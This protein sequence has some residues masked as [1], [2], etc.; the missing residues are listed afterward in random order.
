MK[1]KDAKQIL[2]QIREMKTR[3]LIIINENQKEQTTKKQD[4][5]TDEILSIV[6]G[7]VLN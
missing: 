3:L 6:S 7:G 2:T 5:P 4:Q 1:K